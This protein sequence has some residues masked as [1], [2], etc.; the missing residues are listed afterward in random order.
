MRTRH[1]C[2]LPLLLLLVPP[3]ARADEAARPD[4][5]ETPKGDDFDLMH[6]ERVAD[7]YRW[8][9]DDDAPAVVAWDKAQHALMRKRLDAFPRRQEIR[10]WLS[11]NPSPTPPDLRAAT[12][13]CPARSNPFP[14]S[15]RH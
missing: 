11:D 4:Y 14:P 9:E 7:P 12:T 6:G 10:A 1:L 5:P 2:L 8:L 13:G 3:P 15:K